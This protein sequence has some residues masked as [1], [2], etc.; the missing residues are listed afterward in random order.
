MGV[1][2][3]LV[4]YGSF[5]HPP[6]LSINSLSTMLASISIFT[7]QSLPVTISYNHSA[8]S[9]RVISSSENLIL[10]IP[11]SS[12]LIKSITL[13]SGPGIVTSEKENLTLGSPFPRLVMKSITTL[14]GPGIIMSANVIKISSVSF[15]LALRA[16]HVTSPAA[17]A[18]SKSPNLVAR[19]A[20]VVSMPWNG[21]KCPTNLPKAS[22]SVPA[23]STMGAIVS[24]RSSISLFH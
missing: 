3:T 8:Q 11:S 1:I 9:G 14:S 22:A 19:V 16:V 4:S 18:A 23:T 5:P 2:E 17:I 10:G 7:G 13:P 20:T 21:R 15:S 6:S 24:N 12:R